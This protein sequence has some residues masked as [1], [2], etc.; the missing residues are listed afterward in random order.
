MMNH[1]VI[2]TRKQAEI[3][4]SARAEKAKM[5]RRL[6]ADLDWGSSKRNKDK[7]KGRITDETVQ[8]LITI[9]NHE[10]LR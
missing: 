1:T 7:S 5:R 4:I 2:T 10:A 8:K 6:A 3:I 9:K